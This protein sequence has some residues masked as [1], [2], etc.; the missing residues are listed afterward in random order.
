MPASREQLQ[1]DKAADVD[2]EADA[3][4]EETAEAEADIAIE[5]AKENR[6]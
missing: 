5:Q 6:Q 4:R 1:R 2:P 3:E